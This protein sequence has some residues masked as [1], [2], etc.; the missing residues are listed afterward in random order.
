VRVLVTGHDGYIGSSLVPLLR[1]AGHQVVGLDTY[2]FR[3]CGFGGEATSIDAIHKDIRDVDVEDVEGFDAVIHLAAVSNDPLGE[4]NPACT[5]EINHRA[6]VRLAD[7]ARRAGVVR[8]LF[9]SS[10]SLYGAAGAGLVDETVPLNPV[11]P[12]GRSK[13]LA[14]RDIATLADASFS[15]T[16]LRNATAYGSSPRLRSDLVVNDLV[17]LAATTGE[18]RLSSDGTPWRP[19]VHVEDISRA[20]LALLDAP[21][22]VVHNESFNIGS[23]SQ[24]Y[25]IA[26]VAEIVQGVIPGSR[27]ALAEG[28]GPDRRSYRVS[29]DKFADTF[30]SSRPLWT[31]KEGAEQLVAFLGRHGATSE[32]VMGSRTRRIRHIEELMRDGLL[33][34]DLRWISHPSWPRFAGDGELSR[35]GRS[36]S[37]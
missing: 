20:F 31:V 21:S 2:L 32:D 33:G 4:L 18:A 3:G 12:Y 1:A 7:V 13:I 30:P 19:L 27:I 5:L 22:D 37:P 11:T 17:G 34:L 9:S 10:C 15:P 24:N 28:A 8:F 14:E 6:S 16:F 29:F 35:R 36:P 25:Q 23:N 26:E